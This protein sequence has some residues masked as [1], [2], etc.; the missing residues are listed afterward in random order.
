MPRAVLS[1][2][3][4]RRLGDVFSFVRRS[5]H[6]LPEVSGWWR[7]SWHPLPNLRFESGRART[8]SCGAAARRSRRAAAF[9]QECLSSRGRAGAG[10]SQGRGLDA[11]TITR[12]RIGSLRSASASRTACPRVQRRGA[13]R[14][15]S[16]LVKQEDAPRHHM[17]VPLPANSKVSRGPSPAPN[18]KPEG[19]NVCAQRLRPTTNDDLLQVPQPRN[20][21][22]H[23]RCGRIIAF[24]GR[25]LATDEKVRAEYLIPG[26]RHLLQKPGFV[27]PPILPKMD[28]EFDIASWSRPDGLY[29]RLFRRI[30]QCDC[31]L[32]HG[33]Y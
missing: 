5:R 7:R 19:E 30:S 13:A 29:F 8:P 17:W 9:F 24:T 12:F 27:Q 4:L 15:R 18:D 14:K 16:V 11:E 33:I 20:V 6:H 26:D 2:L 23:Q 1:L 21:S 22:H 3:R 31:Q 10:I 32:W 28:Q 25:T